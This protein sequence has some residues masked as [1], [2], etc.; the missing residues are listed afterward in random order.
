MIR[1]CYD[2]DSKQFKDYSDCS[3]S[4]NFTSF[5]DFPDIVKGFIFDEDI[6]G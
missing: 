3:V 4:E 1:R 2:E 5:D 6:F